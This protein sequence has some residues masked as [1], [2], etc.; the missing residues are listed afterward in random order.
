MWKPSEERPKKAK[1]ARCAHKENKMRIISNNNS[2]VDGDLR[3]ITF[4]G[5]LE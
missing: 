2:K 4:M 3:E 1:V 5:V